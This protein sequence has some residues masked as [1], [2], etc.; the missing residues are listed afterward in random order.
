LVYQKIGQLQVPVQDT[1]FV[2]F[3]Q[4]FQDLDHVPVDGIRVQS[5]ELVHV[6]ESPLQENTPGPKPLEFYDTGQIF[7]V[8][9]ERN[10]S[11]L[12]VGAYPLFESFH[13]RALQIRNDFSVGATTQDLLSFAHVFGRKREM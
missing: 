1:A 11:D 7:Q 2:E 12:A 10:F 4:S 8:P 9:I 3:G 13:H 6:V 5:H